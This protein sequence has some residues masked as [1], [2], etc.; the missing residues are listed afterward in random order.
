MVECGHVHEELMLMG[1]SNTL[2]DTGGESW[3]SC[4]TLHQVCLR[5]LCGRSE[6][7]SVQRSDVKGRSGI[8]RSLCL[9]SKYKG[10]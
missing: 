10:D 2:W 7:G 6:K 9:M 4:W 8:H 5:D 3:V 1:T